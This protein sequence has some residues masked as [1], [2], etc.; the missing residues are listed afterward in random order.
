MREPSPRATRVERF[1]A[2]V[3]GA[4]QAGLSVGYHLATRG[5]DFTV[6]SDESQIGDNWRRRWDSL[7]LFT[8]ARYSGLPGMPFPSSPEHLADKDEVAD[9]FERYA[10]RFDIPVRLGSRVRRLTFNGERFQLSIVGSDTVIEAANVV[11]A[12]GAFQA[13]RTPAIAAS[14]SSSIH[15]LHSSAYRNP[16]E[17]PDGSVLVVGAGNSGAQIALELSRYRKVWLSGRD[18]G[19][20]PRRLFGW[21]LFDWL[22]PVLARVT[23]DTRFGR[24]LR[25]TT[26]R[27]GDALIGIPARTL[28]EAGITRVP[29]LD[30][31]RGGLPVCAGRVIEPRVIIWCTGFAPDYKWIELALFDD[32]GYPRH[33]RGSLVDAPGL[34]FVGLR[35][36]HRLISSL[37]GGVGDD[38]AHI[39]SRVAARCEAELDRGPLSE[40]TGQDAHRNIF[41]D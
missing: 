23:T 28:L 14:L 1:E 3:V 26:K 41:D 20:L 37:M 21:D 10:E 38:A 40:I 5:V 27:G 6:L 24:W 15:Q 22:W 29:R 12:T 9:Y 7:R 2:V 35:F 11:V 18:T 8:P 36:Q 13:P 16:F 31:Q 33:E 34:H 30:G 25:E 32:E 39:A 17:L 19:H 4:G